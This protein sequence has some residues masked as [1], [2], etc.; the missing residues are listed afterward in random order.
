[1]LERIVHVQ[2]RDGE[3]RQYVLPEDVLPKDPAYST[4]ILRLTLPPVAAA[5]PASA[6]ASL[7]AT[8]RD[9][10]NW[11][12]AFLSPDSWLEL[13]QASRGCRSAV[14]SSSRWQ[15]TPI[16]DGHSLRYR[17]EGR[18]AAYVQHR[19]AVWRVAKAFQVGALCQGEH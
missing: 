14:R 11:V 17:P 10:S 7:F 6:A 12:M 8:S 2:G 13:E 1:M 18:K 15:Q 3:V 19:R 5:E 9:A 16:L 4:D